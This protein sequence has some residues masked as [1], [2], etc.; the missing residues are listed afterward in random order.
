MTNIAAGLSQ[1]LEKIEDDTLRHA[2]TGPN[3][4]ISASVE[5]WK[6]QAP[7]MSR[8]TFFRYPQL[9]DLDAPSLHD[10]SASSNL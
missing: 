7:L 4:P 5:P 8:K 3:A 10:R 9:G 2:T 1:A 6:G